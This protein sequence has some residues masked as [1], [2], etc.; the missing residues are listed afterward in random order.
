MIS[1]NEPS[2]QDDQV[3]EQAQLQAQIALLPIKTPL[4]LNEFVNP[5]DEMLIDE[6]GD[7]FMSVVECYSMNNVGEGEEDSDSSEDKV[8]DINTTT[9][10]QCLEQVKLWKLQKGKRKIYRH[11]IV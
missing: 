9:A 5:E 10:L 7:I 4:P 6:D 3:T 2:L 8:E 1:T 11:L